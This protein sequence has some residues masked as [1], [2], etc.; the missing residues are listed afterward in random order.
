MDPEQKVEIG[1]ELSCPLKK[2]YCHGCYAERSIPV[3]I[4][5]YVYQGGASRIEAFGVNERFDR[6]LIEEHADGFAGGSSIRGRG[7]VDRDRFG[8]QAGWRAEVA[9]R[10][11]IVSEAPSQGTSFG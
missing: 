3:G 9:A 5:S 8:A 7:G 1:K 10:S 4:V 11:L 6:L 2:S